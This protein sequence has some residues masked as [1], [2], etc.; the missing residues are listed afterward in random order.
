MKETYETVD[1]PEVDRKAKEKKDKKI[2]KEQE[3]QDKEKI[4]F[5]S[6]YADLVETKKFFTEKLKKKPDSKSLMKS[7]S[8]CKDAIKQLVK[9]TTIS[10]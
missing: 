5:D 7:L 8:D 1:V 2:K 4:A 9:K 3:K 6:E 10:W